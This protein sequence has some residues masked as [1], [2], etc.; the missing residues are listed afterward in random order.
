MYGIKRA[1]V[2]LR[3]MN[4]CRGF[5][6]QSPWAYRLIRYVINEHD[7]YYAYERMEEQIPDLDELTKKRC[8]LYFRLS[9]YSQSHRIINYA[10]PTTAYAAYMKEGCRK[11]SVVELDE[12]T[13]EMYEQFFASHQPIEFIRMNPRGNY[14]ELYEKVLPCTDDHSMMVIED[15]YQG[16]EV[17]DFWKSVVN[18]E[19]TGVTFDLFYCGIIFFDTT[20]YKENYIVNF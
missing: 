13:A 4:H 6:V 3:R 12:G 16:R 2:W 11:S 5:G 1:L 18:D 15:I 9:N 10:S 7:P 19:R 17:K 20:R 14:R 8:R